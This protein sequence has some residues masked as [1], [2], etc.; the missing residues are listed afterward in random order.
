MELCTD[1]SLEIAQPLGLSN[2]YLFGKNHQLTT[3][4]YDSQ[5]VKV[6]TQFSA[7]LSICLN[8]LFINLRH[9]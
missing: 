4:V 2:I 6:P 8:M 9:E 7:I 3:D 5:P 1:F